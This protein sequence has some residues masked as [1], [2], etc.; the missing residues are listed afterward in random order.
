MAKK[1]ASLYPVQQQKKKAKV[2][3]APIEIAPTVPPPIAASP[4]AIPDG[5]TADERRE[6]IALRRK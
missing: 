2:T 4:E 6:W 5:L 1:K 3:I